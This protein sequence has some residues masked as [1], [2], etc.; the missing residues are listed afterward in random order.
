MTGDF[1]RLPPDVTVIVVDGHTDRN[2]LA[3]ILLESETMRA[4]VILEAEPKPKPLLFSDLLPNPV[5]FNYLKKKEPPSEQI[6]P[7]KIR[8]KRKW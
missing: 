4:L 6:H 1:S 8:G 5:T 3:R 7:W 2:A